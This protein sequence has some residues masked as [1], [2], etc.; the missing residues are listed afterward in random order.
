[1][2]QPSHTHSVNLKTRNPKLWNRRVPP[3]FL[4]RSP[5][6][7]DGSHHRGIRRRPESG[8]LMDFTMGTGRRDVWPPPSRVDHIFGGMPFL[9][10]RHERSHIMYWKCG[11]NHLMSFVKREKIDPIPSSLWCSNCQRA[12]EYFCDVR[13]VGIANSDLPQ[14]Q[15]ASAFQYRQILTCEA[16]RYLAWTL[17]SLRGGKA[18]L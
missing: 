16:R 10:I 5:V 4:G 13:S 3:S 9:P 14:S 2:A 1:M 12:S 7:Q 8:S 17:L 11:R 15:R 18:G 6:D